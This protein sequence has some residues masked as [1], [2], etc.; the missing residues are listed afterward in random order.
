MHR[1][2]GIDPS[3]T[4]THYH[5]LGVRD[6]END[7]DVIEQAAEKQLMFLRSKGTSAKYGPAVQRLLNRITSA[8]LTLLNAEKKAAYDQVLA[9]RAE[10]VSTAARAQ[11]AAAVPQAAV[12]PVRAPVPAPVAPPVVLDTTDRRLEKT[13]KKPGP[14]EGLQQYWKQL[15]AGVAGVTLAVGGLVYATAGGDRKV[16]AN[17]D[18]VP[19]AKVP[20]E[21][22]TIPVTRV[23]TPPETTAPA[24]RPSFIAANQDADADLDAAA[25]APVEPVPSVASPAPA[26]APVKDERPIETAVAMENR[27]TP[28]TPAPKEAPA[29]D[30]EQVKAFRARLRKRIDFDDTKKD[31]PT[32]AQIDRIREY[33]KEPMIRNSAVEAKGCIEQMFSFALQ[34]GDLE[35]MHAA[36]VDIKTSPFF[37]KEEVQICAKLTKDLAASKGNVELAS[38]LLEDQV[39]LGAVK[40]EEA[41]KERAELLIVAASHPDLRKDPRKRAD[42]AYALVRSAESI[43]NEQMD[44]ATAKALLT[45]ARTL[46]IVDPVERKEFLQEEVRVRGVVTDIEKFQEAEREMRLDGTNAEARTIVFEH[47]MSKGKVQ[48]A[49]VAL[50]RNHPL[51]KLAVDTLQFTM[52]RESRTGMELFACAEQ[53]VDEAKTTQNPSSKAAKLAL[54]REMLA[55]ALQDT[56]NPLEPLAL[57]DAKKMYADLGG[58]EQL[59]KT[60]LKPMGNNVWKPVVPEQ[61]PRTQEAVRARSVMGEI[62]LSKH[63]MAGEWSRNQRGEIMVKGAYDTRLLLPWKAPEADAYEVTIE[64]DVAR[65]SGS[66]AMQVFLPFGKEAAVVLNGWPEKGGFSGVNSIH[67]KKAEANESK[68]VGIVIE[69]GKKHAVR[70]TIKKDGEQATVLASVDGKEAVRWTGDISVLVPEKES[71]RHPAGTLILGTFESGYVF[72]DIRIKGKQESAPQANQSFPRGTTLDNRQSSAPSTEPKRPKFV[73]R[74]AVWNAETGSWY[75]MM[76]NK[77]S[78]ADANRLA[79]SVSA[80]VVTIDSPQENEFVHSM[81]KGH[82]KWLGFVKNMRDGKLYQTDGTP[83][84]YVNWGRNEGT[85]EREAYVQMSL[86]GTWADYPEDMAVVCLEWKHSDK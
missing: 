27:S 83:A 43:A 75:L 59:L 70:I 39:R 52:N 12:V 58:D 22:K 9:Q 71:K 48:Q 55:S 3:E 47:W 50:T 30:K 61:G 31:K 24:V 63:V 41:A 23:T 40:P 33:L 65:T 21:P 45:K 6:G 76:P 25:P 37:P 78:F 69:N 60:P 36:Y 51:S 15:T 46:L 28:E 85:N 49:V 1:F 35:R 2:L 57:V 32:A 16:E 38:Q 64:L 86:D 82:N 11:V 66:N 77:M 80:T 42:L 54:A 34:L 14:I 17:G 10:T 81:A 67:G 18:N 62:D 56:K 8:K 19:V 13:K 29:V 73:P 68:S 4:P 20:E 72:S 79:A 26:P 5:L 7:P 53:W 44:P 84:A 74:E